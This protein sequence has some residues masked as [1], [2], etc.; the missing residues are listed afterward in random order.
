LGTASINVGLI[1]ASL[2]MS[3]KM[4]LLEINPELVK[5]L[6][7]R[8]NG[9]FWEAALQR[10]ATFQKSAKGRERLTN[11]WC[12]NAMLQSGERLL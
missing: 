4:A 5:S 10:P 2:L 8:M 7:P 11:V 6:C 1:Y 9:R 3:K 12:L